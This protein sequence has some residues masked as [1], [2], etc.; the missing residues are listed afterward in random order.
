MSKFGPYFNQ[1][2]SHSH[3][4][5]Y[6]GFQGDGA[7]AIKVHLDRYMSHFLDCEAWSTHLEQHQEV[8]EVEL[9]S[10]AVSDCFATQ[11]PRFHLGEPWKLGPPI[12][13]TIT[14]LLGALNWAFS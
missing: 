7:L 2:L 6:G 4:N 12:V 11:V 8:T 5:V 1:A 9:Y 10:H 14:Q 3:N 13:A